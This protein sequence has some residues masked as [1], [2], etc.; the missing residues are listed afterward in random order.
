[1]ADTKV[2][3]LDRFFSAFDALLTTSDQNVL[4]LGKSIP[5]PLFAA[6]DIQDLCALAAD[7]FRLQRIVLRIDYEVVI[8]G[9]IHGSFHDLV[10]ILWTHG[11]N[12]SYLF[13]GDYVDRGPFSLECIILL[14]TLLCKYPNQFSL[15]RGNHEMR[16]IAE[17]YGFRHD[18]SIEYPDSVFDAFCTTFSWMPLVAIVQN[19]LFCVHGGIGPSIR[20]L[21]VI[22][23]I[24]RPIVA[25][26]AD[27]VKCLL[28]AD[29]SSEVPRFGQSVRGETTVYGWL[30]V[31]DFLQATGLEAII[32]AHESV[33]AWWTD[34]TMPVTTVFSASNYA[35]GMENSSGV[36]VV[37][38]GQ[39]P[40]PQSYAPIARMRREE[41]MFFM[42][43]KNR[44]RP[45]APV[46]MATVP[47]VR[48]PTT[49]SEPMGGTRYSF[50]APQQRVLTRSV[51]PMLVVAGRRRSE[52][53]FNLGARSRAETFAVNVPEHRTSLE[54]A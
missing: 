42:A 53:C 9:D 35:V 8:V 45:S 16:K 14:F 28:W 11:L 19:R 47:S 32:R 1:M 17:V 21:A 46:G 5:F 48:T 24:E 40:Q 39:P 20:S 15:L 3:V 10:R 27:E 34:K 2:H 51:G 54:G 50:V 41:A 29:P 18:L 7:H 25:D 37:P 23:A 31:K 33:N 4:E 30:A 22:E 44:A 26:S 52:V 36:I 12:A 43:G 49:R 13:L 6:T 38:F